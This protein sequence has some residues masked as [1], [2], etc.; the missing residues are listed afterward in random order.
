[1]VEIGRKLSFHEKVNFREVVSDRNR[2]TARRRCPAAANPRPDR[3]LVTGRR[4]KKGHLR[5]ILRPSAG[6]IISYFGIHQFIL[7]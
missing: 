3:G 5:K 2:P 7:K 6:K 4:L 1:M